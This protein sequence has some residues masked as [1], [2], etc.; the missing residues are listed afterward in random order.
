M[1]TTQDRINLSYMTEANA[2]GHGLF[3]PTVRRLGA[4]PEM[5]DLEAGGLAE[6]RDWPGFRQRGCGYWITAAG[7]RALAAACAR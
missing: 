3:G 4:L 1:L 2:T 5:M 7:R 6:L